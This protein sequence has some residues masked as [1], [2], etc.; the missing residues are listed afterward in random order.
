LFFFRIT[1]FSIFFSRLSTKLA[2]DL[3]DQKGG[4][5]EINSWNNVVRNSSMEL[6]L[7]ISWDGRWFVLNPHHSTRAFDVF[8]YS[9]DN[10]FDEEESPNL[11]YNIHRPCYNF[12]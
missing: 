8:H 2:N 4:T 6:F 3:R 1:I 9:T 10:S 5:P 11:V 12:I 7:P